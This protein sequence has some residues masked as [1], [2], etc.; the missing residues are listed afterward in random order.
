MDQCSWHD[1]PPAISVNLTDR[2]GHDLTLELKARVHGKYSPVSGSVESLSQLSGNF[3]V[4]LVLGRVGE[5][6]DFGL[7][8]TRQFGDRHGASGRQGA[9]KV[10]NQ[11]SLTAAKSLMSKIK[12]VAFTTS[13]NA[14]PASLKTFDP[15]A[16][17][18][19]SSAAV[20]PS[21]SSPVSG[22]SPI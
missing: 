15:L 2:L 21:T 9:L 6:L 22:S 14:A 7:R 20:P 12:I 13:V 1:T 16:R 10:S 5:E 17:A 3:P 8:A 11:T 18:W 4:L 19:R